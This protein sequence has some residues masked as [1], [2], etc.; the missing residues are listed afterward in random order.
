MVG[1]YGG[2]LNHCDLSREEVRH[3]NI[4]VATECE[5][6][7]IGR[8]EALVRSIVRASKVD[9]ASPG[10]KMRV[11]HIL[12]PTDPT[13]TYL[14]ARRV[15]ADCPEVPPEIIPH[16]G[17]TPT[18]SERGPDEGAESAGSGTRP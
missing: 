14:V 6:Y 13:R 9:E 4:A 15:T 7:V 10:T 3:F 11:D 2:E 17:Q 8:D 5:G 1:A 12:H 16:E 18:Q